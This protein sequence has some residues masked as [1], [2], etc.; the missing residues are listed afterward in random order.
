MSVFSFF[1]DYKRQRLHLKYELS[2]TK[3]LAAAV[4]LSVNPEISL[5]LKASAVDISNKWHLSV[6]RNHALGRLF[7]VPMNT[8]NDKNRFAVVFLNIN[9]AKGTTSQGVEF[10]C[11]VEHIRSINNSKFNFFR[12]SLVNLVQ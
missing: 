7:F 8:G 12:V 1:G 11:C 3:D 2:R 6:S 5:S 9:I 10:F 4:S